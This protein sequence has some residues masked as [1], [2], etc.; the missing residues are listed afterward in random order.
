[1]V[2]QIL[3][4]L[5]S[6]FHS[7][8]SWGYN[9]FPSSV[10][11]NHSLNSLA[12][13]SGDLSQ[14]SPKYHSWKYTLKIWQCVFSCLFS[15]DFS[16]DGTAV[17]PRRRCTVGLLSRGATG[18]WGRSSTHLELSHWI[19]QSSF[20]HSGRRWTTTT[21]TG[22]QPT[23]NKSLGLQLTLGCSRLNKKLLSSS[24]V[25][26]QSPHRTLRS[27]GAIFLG[28]PSGPRWSQPPPPASSWAQRWGQRNR[29]RKKPCAWPLLQ[30]ECFGFQF[31]L[32][33]LQ[34]Q[35]AEGAH[36]DAP[37]TQVRNNTAEGHPLRA[38][39]LTVSPWSEHTNI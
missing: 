31:E 5:K 24:N 6:Q 21:V 7:W 3:R 26:A 9:W 35:N 37:K 22:K 10:S 13:Q 32:R 25:L 15:H 1:M 39:L 38:W 36:T 23:T 12:Q 2:P 17:G 14:F 19:L 27:Q 29:K 4:L 20:E 16:P 34:W 28:Q 18:G 33:S 30:P 8:T 11:G